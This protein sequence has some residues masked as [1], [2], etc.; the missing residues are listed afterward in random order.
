MLW[1][2]LI[3]GAALATGRGDFFW[4]DLLLAWS[5][6]GVVLGL[7]MLFAAGRRRHTALRMLVRIGA[8]SMLLILMPASIAGGVPVAAIAFMLL[9]GAVGMSIG[10]YGLLGAPHRVEG[11]TTSPS[12]RASL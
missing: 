1:H 5:I 12:A 7:A 10:C 9:A 8:L 11:P 4:D 3:G 2:I 6:L